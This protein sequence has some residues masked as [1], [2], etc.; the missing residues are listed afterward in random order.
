MKS[1]VLAEET[2]EK[3]GFIKKKLF[4]A[5]Y[6]EREQSLYLSEYY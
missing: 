6:E 5:V 1:V 4:K 2:G 3:C